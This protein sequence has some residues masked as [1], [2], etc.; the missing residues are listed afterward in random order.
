MG[1]CYMV[2]IIDVG[3]GN[4][5][6][7]YRA[8]RHLKVDT[9]VSASAA[10]IEKAEKLVFP[11]VG[12]FAEAS[13]RL[14][15]TGMADVIRH[16][17]VKKNKPILGICLGMQLL[18]NKGEEGG[19]SEGLGLI[20]ARVARM[21]SEEKGSRLPHI[22]WNDVRTGGMRIFSGVEDPCFYFVHSYSMELE[23]EVE[24]AVCDYGGDFVAVVKKDNIM[25]VQFHPEKSQR[26]G[27][28]LLKNFVEGVF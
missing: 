4:V 14:L 27:L 1:M 20:N 6:S 18:A 5:N 11:G 3:L 19:R 8:L 16:E 17:V 10:D 23:E 26:F 28:R 2:T 13:K 15:S 7:V 12:N 24:H 25:G 21:K 22:G 9:C